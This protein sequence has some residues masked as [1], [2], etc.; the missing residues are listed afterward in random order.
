M[1]VAS[2][3]IGKQYKACHTVHREQLPDKTFKLK[4][5]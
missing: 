5:P 2:G 3:T 4:A 1:K